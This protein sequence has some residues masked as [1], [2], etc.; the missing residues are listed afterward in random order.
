M[1]FRVWLAALGFAA[2]AASG[3]AY[4]Q[5]TVIAE[6]RA[7]LK[8]MGEHMEAMKPISDARGDPR[9][10]LARIDDMIAWYTV[11]PS[12]FPPGSGT[13][14]TKALPAIWQEF[15][16]FEQAN[17]ALL[18]QLATLR[19]AAAA[20]T[21]PP[22]RPPTRPPARNSAAAATGLSGR[23]DR[24]ARRRGAPI[25]VGGA[26]PSRLTPQTTSAAVTSSMAA[27]SGEPRRGPAMAS[28]RRLRP[29]TIGR[30]RS[31][32]FTTA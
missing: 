4:A 29:V 14:D 17:T 3:A 21:R 16:R 19:A 18:G 6:R 22:S 2:M 25:R 13:G 30:T 32:R 15:P 11:L 10:A 28:G 9:P 7:G 31:C 24:Q 12:K 26:Q 27:S 23:A 20:A 5:S 8:R 1:T